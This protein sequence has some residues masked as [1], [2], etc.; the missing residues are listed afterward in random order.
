MS[1]V[2][3]GAI[4][5]AYILRNGSLICYSERLWRML[6]FELKRTGYILVEDKEIGGG[7]DVEMGLTDAV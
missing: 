1:T 2:G 7:V 5:C 3:C 6:I 4:N